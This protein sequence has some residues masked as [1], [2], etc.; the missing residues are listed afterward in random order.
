MEKMIRQMIA[1]HKETDGAEQ[2]KEMSPNRK[3]VATLKQNVNRRTWLKEND[4]QPGKTGKPIKSNIT[5]NES[6]TMKTSHGV[7]QGDHGVAVVD[8]KH[9]IV[10]HAE[11]YGAPQEHELLQPM[12]E[13][14][15]ENLATI[16]TPSVFEQTKLTATAASIR[17]RTCSCSWSR[18]SMPT[19]QT[20]SSGNGF[21]LRRKRPVQG[22]A[23]KRACR[24]PLDDHRLYD[25]LLHHE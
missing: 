19:W 4:E 15:R 2:N 23:S 14:T 22:S 9:Q 24:L 7:V 5:D 1:R 8:N 20:P 16:G 10:V 13:G 12:V 18:A 3:Y 11:A 6:A 21:P 25:T 17:K